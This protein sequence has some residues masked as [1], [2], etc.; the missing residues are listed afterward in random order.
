M[1]LRFLVEDGNLLSK[2]RTKTKLPGVTSATDNSYAV[3]FHY[4]RH[5]NTLF[6][7]LY[8]TQKVCIFNCNI[9]TLFLLFYQLRI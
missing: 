8:A 9:D 7:S 4:R 5:L 2:V 6:F 3:L 1:R